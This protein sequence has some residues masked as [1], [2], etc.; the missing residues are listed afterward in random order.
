MEICPGACTHLVREKI[1]DRNYSS[2]QYI[3]NSSIQMSLEFCL[4]IN[5]HGGSVYHETNRGELQQKMQETDQPKKKNYYKFLFSNLTVYLFFF[6][7]I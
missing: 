2:S 6:V 5:T 4:V 1:D 3:R 7:C